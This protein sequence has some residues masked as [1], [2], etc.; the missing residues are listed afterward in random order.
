MTVDIRKDIL[1]QVKK[2]L[3]K[4]GSAVLTGKDGLDIVIIEQ[5]WSGR[6]PS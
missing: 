4:I 3:I 5:N 6:S 1:G 2:T